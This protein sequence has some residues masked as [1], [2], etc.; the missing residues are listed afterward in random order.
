MRMDLQDMKMGYGFP[1]STVQNSTAGHR[2]AVLE[3]F[4]FPILTVALSALTGLG[5]L[6]HNPLD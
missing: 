6:P 1:I 5:N 2:A 4:P 3:L